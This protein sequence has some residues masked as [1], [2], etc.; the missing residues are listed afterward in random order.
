MLLADP[1]SPK[2]D[3]SGLTFLVGGSALPK[4]LAEAARRRGVKVI[5]G[6]GLTETAQR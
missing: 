2:Y 4:G 3:L 6:Y 5:V 1:E